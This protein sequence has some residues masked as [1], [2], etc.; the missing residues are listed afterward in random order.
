MVALVKPRF[1]CFSNLIGLIY[2]SSLGNGK[3][4][5][6]VGDLAVRYFAA[7]DAFVFQRL[8]ATTSAGRTLLSQLPTTW[9]AFSIT[10]RMDEPLLRCIGWSEHYFFPVC[11]HIVSSILLY[12]V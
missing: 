1:D 7:A 2:S 9:P 6:S 8:P 3:P 4:W 12:P 10:E 5:A 11:T